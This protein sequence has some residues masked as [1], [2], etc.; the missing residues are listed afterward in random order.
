MSAA[1][2]NKLL[3][4]FNELER[5]INLTK[6]VLAAKKS[7]PAEVIERVNQYSSIVARQRE[8]AHGLKVHIDE[9]NWEE[10]ARHVKLINGLS[11][12][13]RDDAQ[14]ILL[15]AAADKV[16]VKSQVLLS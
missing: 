11:S 6:E 8:L 7:V 16:E 3:D 13:I 15:G 9:Q 1:L 14:A 5:C 12:M 10:V 4:S 2:V